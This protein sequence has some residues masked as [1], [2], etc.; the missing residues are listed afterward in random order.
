MSDLVKVANFVDRLGAETAKSILESNGIDSQVLA[1]DARG[2]GPQLLTGGMGAWVLVRNEDFEMAAELLKDDPI[3][4]QAALE[5]EAM[6]Y[7]PPAD[8]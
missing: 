5:D 1:D 6:S 4:D 3:I 8:A 7:P 2:A